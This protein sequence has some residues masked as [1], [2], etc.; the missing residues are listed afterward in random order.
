MK[1]K[2]TALVKC[3]LTFQKILV[4]LLEWSSCPV[5]VKLKKVQSG[6]TLATKL[7]GKPLPMLASQKTSLSPGALRER[8]HQLRPQKNQ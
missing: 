6:I 1:F 2:S 7:G 5:N 8:T 4:Q 3:S